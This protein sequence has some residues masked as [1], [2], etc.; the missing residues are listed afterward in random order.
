M[1]ARKK[2]SARKAKNGKQLVIVESPAKAKTI[3]KFLGSDYEVQASIGHVRDLPSTRSE[4]TDKQRENKYSAL[5]VDLEDDFRPMYVIPPGKREQIRN[6]KAALKDAP[7]LWLATDEDREGE[8]ISWHL[9]EVLKPKV[10][11]HRLVFHEITNRAIKQALDTPREIDANLVRAQESRRILDRLFGYEVSPVLWRKIR[12]KLSAGR[13]QSVALRL[14]V[15]RE[16]ERIAFE[17]SEWWDIDALFATRGDEAAPFE[18]LLRRLGDQ[19]VAA[20]GDFDRTTG[21]LAKDNVRVLGEKDAHALAERLAGKT[22]VVQDVEEKEF[23]ERPAPPFTTSTLQQE[24]GRKLRYSSRRAMSLAQQLYEN[25]LITYMRTDSTALSTQAVDAAR[26]LIGERYGAAYLP[27]SPRTYKTKVK[28]AQEAHEAIRPAGSRFA[29]IDE[30]RASQGADAARLYELIWKRTVA[31]QMTDARGKRVV[32]RVAVDDAL[33]RAS[34]KTIEF[35]G[36]RRAYVEGSDDPA[37]ELAEQES[38]LPPLTPGQELDVRQLEPKGHTTQ[39]PARYTEASIVKALDQRGIGRPSTWAS[40]IQVLLDREYAFRK[41]GRTLVPSFT[42]FAVV[43]MLKESFGRLLSYDFTASMEDDLDAISRGEMDRIEYLKRFY[44]GN[45]HPGLHQLVQKGLDTIDPREVCSFPLGEAGGRTIEVRVGKYG[46]FVSDGEQN[47]SLREDIVPDE[48]TAEAALEMI[49]VAARGPQ[50][51]G[52][53]PETGKPVYAKSGRFGPYVQLGD[54]VEGSKEKPKMVSLL[55]GMSLETMDLA[56]AL[57][58]LELPRDLG[59]HPEDEEKKHVFA[60]LGRYGPYVKW[61]TESRS[62]PAEINLLDI[63]LA[64]AVALLKAPRRRR[65]QRAP[66]APLKELGEHPVSGE[67]LKILD[68]RWGPYVTDGTVNASLPK[69]VPPDELTI[70][71]AVEL[72]ARRAERMAAKKGARRKGG[73]KKAAKKKAAKKKTARKKAAKKKAVK[74][75]AAK[76]KAAPKPSDE[77]S[78]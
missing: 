35:P 24:A 15:E 49:E 45:G 20:S 12:P 25:G 19:P 21:K 8:S 36:F 77:A 11:V 48:L 62:I 57:R 58:L 65:G 18:A 27:E 1:A 3:G 68:G 66:A 78:N 54:P 22:A 29:S 71:E 75:A 31:S 61:G 13:V 73:R 47:A 2:T 16:M 28:N 26:G 10:P 46:L 4:L 50:A 59:E 32:V 17:P 40:I 70:N 72:L 55:E 33:F 74:K 63:E 43:R 60:H 30:V 34:G 6:L 41:G 9:L 5:G 56:T 39:P 7:A 53:C 14:L 44:S 64:A 51:L 37:A 52:N 38:L 67:P 76:K 42:A 23:K 69:S